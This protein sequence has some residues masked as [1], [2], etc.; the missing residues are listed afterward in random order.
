[1]GRGG[2]CWNGGG[3]DGSSSSSVGQQLQQLF[4]DGGGN[5][6]VLGGVLLQ[7][8]PLLM[9]LHGASPAVEAAGLCLILGSVQQ[10]LSVACLL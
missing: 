10:H 6:E 4:C 2:L 1:V 3:H 7:P 9:Q 5:M 8:R